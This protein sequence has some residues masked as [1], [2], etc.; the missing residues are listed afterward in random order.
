MAALLLGTEGA[1]S[2]S[3]EGDGS[4]KRNELSIRMI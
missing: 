3:G 4:V 2:G 1:A